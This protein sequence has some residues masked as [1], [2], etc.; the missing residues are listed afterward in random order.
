[1]ATVP[2]SVGAN[3]I[4]SDFG[5]FVRYAFRMVHGEKLRDQPY[6]GHLCYMISRLVD[7]EINRLLINLP[8]QHLKASWGLFVS[9]H[10]S[11]ARTRG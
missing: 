5:A 4:R 3:L 9:Q 1:M 10:I 8:P 7:G 2:R 11:L 6:V